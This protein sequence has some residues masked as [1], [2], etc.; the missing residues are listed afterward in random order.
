MKLLILIGFLFITGGLAFNGAGFIF[1][2]YHENFKDCYGE[3]PFLN[4]EEDFQI[5]VDNPA[6]ENAFKD[7][8]QTLCM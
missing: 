3:I 2:D 8:I 7:T 5:R 4:M 1:S 6:K